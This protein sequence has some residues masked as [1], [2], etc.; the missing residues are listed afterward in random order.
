MPNAYSDVEYNKLKQTSI[1]AMWK[2]KEDEFLP[3]NKLFEAADTEVTF[4]TEKG[5]EIVKTATGTKM[6]TTKGRY[7]DRFK[8]IPKSQYKKTAQI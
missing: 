7:D 6:K 4:E 3:A 8:V 2:F 5:E 1:W